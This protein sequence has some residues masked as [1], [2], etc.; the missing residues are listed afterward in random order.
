MCAMGNMK[1]QMWEEVI[2]K[3]SL[4]EAKLVM[5]KKHSDAWLAFFH[6]W[7]QQKATQ[8]TLNYYWTDFSKP[9][10][11]LQVIGLGS[12]LRCE[13]LLAI[14]CLNRSKPSNLWTNLTLK[15]KHTTQRQKET[16]SKNLCSLE[17][18]YFEMATKI[19]C[20]NRDWKAWGLCSRI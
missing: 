12:I 8:V 13:H 5:K 7:R 6:Q 14:I 9:I 3:E 4:P 15:N 10:T 19:W 1:E 16:S 18:K 2:W 20:Q 17:S 11:S